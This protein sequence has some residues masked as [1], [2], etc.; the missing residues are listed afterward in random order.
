MITMQ[1]WN[2]MNG[3]EQTIWLEENCKVNGRGGPR[4]MVYGVGVNDAPYCSETRIDGK[5]V[6]CPAYRAWTSMLT[7]AYSAKYHAKCPT[8]MGIEICDEWK[9]FCAFRTWWIKNQVDGWE[10]DKDILS[11]AGLYSPETCIFAPAWL[12]SFTLDG[13]Q[14]RGLYP[15]GVSFHNGAGR[16]RARC[17]NPI[18]RND[19]YLGLFH[20]QEEAHLAW[21][22]RKL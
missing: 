4:G 5:Q 1:E 3:K 15:I 11:D 22:K 20:T 17:R 7:R 10:V 19:E 12:N 6:R 13:G 16:F 8:Y 18:A 9:N 21:L 14:A 2:A